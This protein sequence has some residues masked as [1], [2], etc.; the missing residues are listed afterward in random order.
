MGRGGG[1]LRHFGSASLSGD[2]GS[3]T[4]DWEGVGAP[5]LSKKNHHEALFEGL[6]QLC[7]QVEIL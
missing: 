6:F 3:V 4:V 5:S 7:V 1:E 2:G